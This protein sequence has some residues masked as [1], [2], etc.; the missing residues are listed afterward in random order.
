M[1]C[2]IY[3]EDMPMILRCTGT[4]TIGQQMLWLWHESPHTSTQYCLDCLY[5]KWDRQICNDRSVTRYVPRTLQCTR[6][7]RTYLRD[8]S[9]IFANPIW[10]KDSL[11]DIDYLCQDIHVIATASAGRRLKFRCT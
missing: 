8:R 5:A 3:H 11:S 6:E 9:S 10:H 7:S 2:W 4:S 1:Q